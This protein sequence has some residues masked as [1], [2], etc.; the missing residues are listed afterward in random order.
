MDAAP[1]TRDV[2]RQQALSLRQEIPEVFR[3]FGELSRSSMADGDLP[4]LTKEYA[5]LAISMVKECDGCIVAHLRN[6]I[7]LGA[8]RRQIAELAGVAI[9]M[10]G[11]PGTVWGPRTLAAYDELVAEASGSPKR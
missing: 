5:A 7:R 9:M 6:L 4:A 10:D 8:T 3:A 11:G 1:Q 2:L